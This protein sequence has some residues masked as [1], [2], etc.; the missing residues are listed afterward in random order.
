M[1]Q[2][3]IYHKYTTTMA[4]DT[5]GIWPLKNLSYTSAERKSQWQQVN[6]HSLGKCQLKWCFCMTR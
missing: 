2:V 6:P 3:A 5:N 4:D 1:T